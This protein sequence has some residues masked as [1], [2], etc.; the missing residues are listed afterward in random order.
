[1]RRAAAAAAAA[2]RYKPA[3]AAAAAAAAAGRFWRQLRRTR[4][5]A[6]ARGVCVYVCIRVAQRS[7]LRAKHMLNVKQKL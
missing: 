4:Y 1:M 3:A 6:C 7:A 5:R 2:A